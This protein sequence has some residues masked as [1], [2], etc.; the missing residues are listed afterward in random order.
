MKAD[1]SNITLKDSELLAKFPSIADGKALIT[2][3]SSPTKGS[4]GEEYYQLYLVQ[5]Q[6]R[7]SN[8]SELDRIFLAW[9]AARV[10][11][12]RT[13]RNVKVSAVK[14]TEIENW[15]VGHTMEGVSIEV[16]HTTVK[17]YATATPI[18]ITDAEGK[19][20]I[21]CTEAKEPVYK[22]TKLVMGE[23]KHNFVKLVPVPAETFKGIDA[24]P[25]ASP[26]LQSVEAEA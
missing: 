23:P 19:E 18:R 16:S 1:I 10:V 4:D 15:A 25:A 12:E 9:G 20:S 22:T 7:E 8:A 11:N 24:V 13:I 21:M 6:K 26:L 3:I 17:P 5:Q 2:G 14:G